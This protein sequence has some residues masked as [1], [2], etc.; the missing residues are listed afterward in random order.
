[1]FV[2]YT[3]VQNPYSVLIILQTGSSIVGT[4]NLALV[5]SPVA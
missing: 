5:D 1:M 2:V 4:I 3:I